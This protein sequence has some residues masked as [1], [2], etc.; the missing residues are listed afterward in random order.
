MIQAYQTRPE[1]VE[2][3][4]LTNEPAMTESDCVAL[5]EWGKPWVALE[6]GANDTIAAVVNQVEGRVSARL[7]DWLIR[8]N[9][10]RVRVYSNEEFTALFEP[11][12]AGSKTKMS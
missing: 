2:A 1:P 5:L 7:G 11:A 8:R 3:V 9:G 12:T 6:S 10:G 4:C